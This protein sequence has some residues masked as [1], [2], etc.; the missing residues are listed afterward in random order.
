M[1]I[2]TYETK[3]TV[4]SL[5]YTFESVGEKVIKKGVIYSKFENPNDIGLSA[6]LSV[7]NLGFGDVDEERRP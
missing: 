3:S 1:Q 5:I 2:E 6:N 4:D 7:Y